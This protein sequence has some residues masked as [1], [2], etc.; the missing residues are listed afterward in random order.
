VS[1]VDRTLTICNGIHNRG[2]LGAVRCLTDAAVR[3][4]NEKYLADRFPEGEFA[5][6][7]R[8]RV[9]GDMSLSPHLEI[10]QHVCA[11]GN[12]NMVGR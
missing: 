5:I 1:R 9:V 11:S 10:P 2:V 7:L 4:H 8:E 12:R 3:G 6:L